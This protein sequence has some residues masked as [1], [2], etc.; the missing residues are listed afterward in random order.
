M[1]AEELLTSPGVAMGTVAYMSPEQARGEPLDAR[2][3][4]F[5]FGGV[6]YEMATGRQPFAGAT[7]AIVFNA[8]LSSS[9]ISPVRLNPDLPPELERIVHKALEKDRDVRYQHAS[10]LR[11]DLK[12]LKRDTDSGRSAATAAA[13][14][15]IETIR[16]AAR[17]KSK[18]TLLVVAAAV[19]AVSLGALFWLTRPLPP[20][21][22]LRYTPLTNDARQK[23]VQLSYPRPLTD[24]AR[25]YFLED[26][27]GRAA[28]AQVS[29]SGGETALVSTPFP[30]LD[31]WDISP[32]R[33]QLL[34]SGASG[35]QPELALWSLPLPAGTPRR[36]GDVV[37]H[38]ASWSPDQQ[39]IVYARGTDLYI[40][41]SDGSSERKLATASGLLLWPRWSPNGKV[42]RFT[43]S[44]RS[45]ASSIWEVGA[46]GSNLHRLLEGWSKPPAECC[47]NWTADGR[48]FI[49]QSVRGGIDSICAMREGSG[50]FARRE[51]EP[52]VLT[53]GPIHYLSPVP[54]LDGKKLFVIG[55]QPRGEL[56]RYD[57]KSSQ[58]VPYLS[59]ISAHGLGFSSDGKWVAYVSYP[60]GTVWRSRIDGSERLQLTFSPL[61]AA[62]AYWSPDGKSIAF[63]G[64]E[65]GK[66]W[67]VYVVPAEGGNARRLSPED[68]NHA[69]PTWSP[70][71]LSLAFGTLPPAE[72]D[73]AGGIFILD[74]KTN[75][76]S[77]VPGSENMFSPHWSPDGRYLNAQTTDSL[78]LTLFDFKTRKWTE[79]AKGLVVGYPN[80]SHDG[81][82]LYYDAQSGEQV[83][84]Y[85][86]RISD[87]KVERVADLR[88]VRR[89]GALGAWGGLAPDDSPLLLRDTGTQEIYALDVDFP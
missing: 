68:R 55:D 45:Q 59:G 81:K 82:Y 33:S 76:I 7:S 87:F 16:P 71:G 40:A 35:L 67:Q 8:I 61:A 65:P 60:E 72:P 21:R 23:L 51:S 42:L 89:A 41:N 79:M 19:L 25:V 86:I 30:D 70:D 44:E 62:Q 38:E 83:G 37:G 5:S 43:V 58:F 73:N 50:L 66:S 13:A 3:D 56:T 64:V 74:L 9:P 34:I 80:W 29:A 14:P 46:D 47:G 26:T 49:F 12:R 84:F 24:G 85:R 78:K 48:Y 27:G 10:D 1:T 18:K 20:P 32:D 57:V 69:D 54:S 63:M 4:L 53:T 11:A 31:L 39:Q 22:V 36:L 75:Q 88:A 15:G 2:T 17:P 6:V 28:L 52:F 77:K